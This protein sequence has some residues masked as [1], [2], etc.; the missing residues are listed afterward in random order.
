[1]RSSFDRAFEL[2]VGAEGGYCNVAGD[3]GGETNYGICKRAYPNLDIKSITLDQAKS[4]YLKDYWLPAGCDGLDYP[5]DICVFDCAVNQ[6]LSRA[7]T[8]QKVSTCWQDFLLRRL[9]HYK[10]LTPKMDKFY[11]GWVNRIVHLYGELK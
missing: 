3:P 4:I 1:M 10:S 9:E 2:V 5:Y 8:F 11:K 6:G 7:A